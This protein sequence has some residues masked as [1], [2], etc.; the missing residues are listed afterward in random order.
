MAKDVKIDVTCD[1]CGVLKTYTEEGACFND[2]LFY[3]VNQDVK[4]I[5]G[6]H[7]ILCK[8][9]VSKGRHKTAW[10]QCKF[11]FYDTWGAMDVEIEFPGMH[12]NKT[13]DF[14][15]WICDETGKKYLTFYGW[16]EKYEQIDTSNVVG[17]YE[18]VKIEGE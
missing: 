18:L 15:I 6:D 8:I 7:E 5:F 16:D 13:V 14:N 17:S 2:G 4:D 10:E 1:G 11:P 3:G 9:C 12:P